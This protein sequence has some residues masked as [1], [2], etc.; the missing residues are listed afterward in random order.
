[1][2]VAPLQHPLPL[3]P[4]AKRLLYVKTFGCQMNEYD[5]LRVQRLLQ[6]QGYA[7][8]AEIAA[9]DVIFLN[10]CSVREKAEQKVYSFLGRLRHLKAHRPELRI[11]VAGCV[12]Q[13]LGRQLLERFDH[14]DLVL[15]TRGISAIAELLGEIQKTGKRTSHLPVEAAPRRP[16]ESHPAS[17]G[18]TGE[19]IAPVTI[20]QGC[21][22]FCTYCIVPYVRGPERSRPLKDILHEIQALT[23]NGVRE[24]LLLGQNVNS[25]GHGLDERTDFVDLLRHIQADTDVRRLRFTTSH[26]KDLTAALV[27]CLAT[28]PVLCKNLHL[29]VQAGSDRILMLMNR[30]YTATQYLQKIV[31]LREVCPDIGLTSDVMV[32]FPGETE[33]DFQR[34]LR[35]LEAVQFDNLFSFRYSDRPDAASG[36]FPDK[37]DSRTKARRLLELQSLQAEITLGKNLQEVAKIRDV[38][39]EGPSRAGNGQ[40]SGRTQQNRVVNFV[41]SKELI[42]EIICVKI[43]SA[44][45]H[46]LKGELWQQ[47]G[48][49]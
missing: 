10:T 42:G 35:L 8:T 44:Y 6:A 9:A 29:P 3:A 24:I 21:N 11:I 12:A 47:R 38:L 25:Y 49:L 7:M 22:N 1:M 15:G 20:M 2:V 13:Q 4:P 34:T 37:V 5:S 39:V 45:S 32:G 41:G 14:V 23:A 18:N 40:F 16:S 30:G 17:A 46:S 26:P 33:E 31:H 43:T 27:Q 48:I 28:L 19:V 36:E